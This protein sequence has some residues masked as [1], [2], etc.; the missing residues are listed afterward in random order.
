MSFKAI[1]NQ[2]EQEAQRK[3]KDLDDSTFVIQQYNTPIGRSNELIR[4][5]FIASKTLGATCNY[6][7]ERISLNIYKYLQGTTGV[8]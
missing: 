5:C 2:D 3:E 6:R 4:D 1:L 7:K 8:N